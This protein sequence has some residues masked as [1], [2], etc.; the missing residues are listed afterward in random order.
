MVKKLITNNQQLITKGLLCLLP[1]TFGGK[2][3]LPKWVE[4]H[5]HPKYPEK[6]Y[7]VGIGV[8]QQGLEPAKEAARVDLA[9]QIKIEIKST[10]KD[11]YTAI[12]KRQGKKCSQYLI[13][14][15]EN[16]SEQTVNATLTGVQIVETGVKKG[17]YY[18]LAVLDKQKLASSL[19]KEIATIWGDVNNLLQEGKGYREKGKI[20]QAIESFVRASNL[21]TPALSKEALLR[22]VSVLKQFKHPS[23]ED[24]KSEIQETVSILSIK[25]TKGDNQTVVVGQ[26]SSLSLEVLVLTG[27]NPVKSAPVIFS[28]VDGEEIGESITDSRG[29]ASMKIMPRKKRDNRIAAKLSIHSLPREFEE[30]LRLVRTIFSY[31]LIQSEIPFRVY[32]R[33]SS[34]SIEKAVSQSVQELGYKVTDDA[35]FK[36]TGSCKTN[37]IDEI[38]GFSVKKYVAEA[39]LILTIQERGKEFESLSHSIRATGDTKEKAEKNAIRKMKSWILSRKGRSEFSNIISSAL[40]R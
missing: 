20:V 40:K 7:I 36:I 29:I 16:A 9:S 5:H 8:T 10:L 14:R 1:F 17:T 24:L 3:N 26:A 4:T 6:L 31:E 22:I 37:I 21:F 12:E 39:S 34:L 38:E 13:S 27:E 11:V 28:Y 15:V 19:S 33:P 35:K 18:A 2:S 23:L 30:D 25:K 32:I